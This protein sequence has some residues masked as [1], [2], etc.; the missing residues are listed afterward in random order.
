GLMGRFMV[1]TFSDLILRVVLA[2]VF[3]GIWGA[4]GIW[5]AWP[6]GW[7]VG[8]VLSLIFY[9]TAPCIKVKQKQA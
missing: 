3:S 5:C 6:V 2:I 9:R 1:D 8:T 7:S 4:R